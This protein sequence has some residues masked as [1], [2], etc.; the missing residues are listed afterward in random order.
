MRTG[1][2]TSTSG[3]FKIHTF[4]SSS[5]FVVSSISN[6][7]GGGDEVSYV[8]VAGGGGGGSIRCWRWR[9]CGGFRERRAANDS[10]TVSPL[11]V[12]QLTVT[13]QLILLQ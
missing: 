3:N 2:T 10:Y 11:N 4:N 12:Q 7:A 13:A 1:G 6:T 9:W 5:K 8:V